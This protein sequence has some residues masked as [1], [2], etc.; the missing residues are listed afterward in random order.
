MYKLNVK[1]KSFPP[2]FFK[3]IFW[4][5]IS[6]RKM[7]IARP[8]RKKKKQLYLFNLKIG[9]SNDNFRRFSTIPFFLFIFSVK[10]VT[11]FYLK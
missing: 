6:A 4:G 7:Q 5:I 8:R 1:V 11:L 9:P 2:T 3:K 10:K